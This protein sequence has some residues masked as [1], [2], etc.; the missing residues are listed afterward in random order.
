MKKWSLSFVQLPD[1]MQ[2]Y[3]LHQ[4]WLITYE[5]YRWHLELDHVALSQNGVL[6]VH[7]ILDTWLKSW[8]HLSA[9][10][11]KDKHQ[12]KFQLHSMEVKIS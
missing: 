5:V 3:N 2:S 11:I 9:T 12:F 10:S 4:E 8:F 1:M 6:S 7:Y